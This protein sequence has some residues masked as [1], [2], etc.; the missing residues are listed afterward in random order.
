[1]FSTTG[2]GTLQIN[3]MPKITSDEEC[4]LC[5]GTGWQTD[6]PIVLGQNEDGTDILSEPK[7]MMCRCAL[8]EG[9]EDNEEEDEDYDDENEDVDDDI[10]SPF[11]PGG[12]LVPAH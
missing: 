8:V 11:F 1:M 3:A 5:L 9:N 2:R 7:I 12:T 4:V 6:P 10:S